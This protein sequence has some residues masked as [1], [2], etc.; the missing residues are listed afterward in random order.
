MPTYVKIRAKLAELLTQSRLSAQLVP[1][2]TQCKIKPELVFGIAK[3]GRLNE[4][5]IISLVDMLGIKVAKDVQV[6]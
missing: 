1:N 3:S 6:E 5:E 4:K 2:S